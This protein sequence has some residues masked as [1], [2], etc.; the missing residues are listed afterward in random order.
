MVYLFVLPELMEFLAPQPPTRLTVLPR[1]ILGAFLLLFGIEAVSL[2]LTVR[3]LR[4]IFSETHKEEEEETISRGKHF[5]ENIGL[6]LGLLMAVIGFE[7]FG[8]G[9]KDIK[10]MW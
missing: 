1:L 4:K 9:F 7:L 6:L 5:R 8:S 10:A 2:H 3:Q